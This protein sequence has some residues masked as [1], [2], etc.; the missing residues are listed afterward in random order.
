MILNCI[1]PRGIAWG[2]FFRT[3]DLGSLQ[4]EI[5]RTGNDFISPENAVFI[6]LVEGAFLGN[7]KT[8]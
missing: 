3:N 4:V 2:R 5:G 7:V 1:H 6:P 8:H